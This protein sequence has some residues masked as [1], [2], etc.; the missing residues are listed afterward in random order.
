MYRLIALDIDDTLLEAGGTIHPQN[1]AAIAEAQERGCAVTLV[2]ARS[3][4]ATGQFAAQI[5]VTLPV[6][7]MTGATIC[8]PTGEL[9]RTTPVALADARRLAGWAD[10]EQWVMRLYFA[11]GRVIQSRPTSDYLNKPGANYPA[12]SYAGDLVSHLAG[13]ESSIQVVVLGTRAVEGVL[14]RLPQLPG[15]I[16]TT[17]ERGTPSARCHLLHAAVSKG[18]ALATLCADLG[19]AQS[20]TIAMGDGDADI[21]MIAWAGVGVAMGWA[22]A[23]VRQVADLVMDPADPHPVA[24]GIRRLL[25]L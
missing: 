16:A 2:T 19:V 21:S 8:S 22:P 15:V 9:L 14:A 5:G 20:E 7:C 13:G 6:I 23:T 3:W 1:V 10:A 17:Y 11:D 12:E 18:A 24:T 25:C 4:R